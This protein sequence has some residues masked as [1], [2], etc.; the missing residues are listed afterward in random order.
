MK[1]ILQQRFSYLFEQELLNDMDA[2]GTYKEVKRDEVLIDIGDYLK[3]MPIMLE[4]AIKIL[5]A[6][7]DGNEVLLYY[8]EPG[9]TCAMTLTC[10]VNH[11]KSNIKAVAET[12]VKLLVVP[13]SK[14]EEWLTYKS[15]RDFVFESY[16]NRLNEMLEAIDDLAFLNLQERLTKYLKNSVMINSTAELSLTHQKIAYEL[17]TSRVVVSRLLKKLE[18]EGEIK[19]HRNKVEVLHF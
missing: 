6:D 3:N 18:K 15:W 1:E 2:C 4:G 19:L 14:M 10:C 16:N 17:N 5:K 12:E 7:D 9:D 8:L 13:T 11:K